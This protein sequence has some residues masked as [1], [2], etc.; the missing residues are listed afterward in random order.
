MFNQENKTNHNRLIPTL[1]LEHYHG[2]VD[3]WRRAYGGQTDIE[4]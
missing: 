2:F 1:N 3:G 4:N